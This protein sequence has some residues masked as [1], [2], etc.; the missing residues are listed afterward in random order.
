M[1]DKIKGFITDVVECTWSN[2]AKP[3][4]AFGE[5]SANHNITIVVDASLNT[6]LQEI[7]K[8]SGAKKL[9]G[10]KEKN[11]ITTLKV[12]TKA[13]IEKGVFP[14]Y[15]SQANPSPVVAM[16]GDKVKLK[17]QPV[18]LTRD[19]TL[20]LY[21]NGVQIITKGDRGPLGGSGFK[22]IDGGFIADQ[23][24]ASSVPTTEEDLPF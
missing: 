5:G 2:L 4:T 24:K 7:L 9:N 19:K 12:K 23:P 6:K 22:P 1:S 10:I 16:G 14:C 21:L 3:D 17:L 13:H 20:S 18:V 11:G 8:K 15:D